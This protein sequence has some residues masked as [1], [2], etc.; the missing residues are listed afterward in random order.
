[1]RLQIRYHPRNQL[2][3]INLPSGRLQTTYSLS[4]GMGWPRSPKCSVLH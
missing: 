1:M 4:C 2:G 3:T